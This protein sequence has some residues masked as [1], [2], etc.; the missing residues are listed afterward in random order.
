MTARILSGAYRDARMKTPTLVLVGADD[1]IGPE[2]LHGID[3]HVDDFAMEYVEGAKE[4]CVSPLPAL[5]VMRV[6]RETTRP[7]WRRAR[8][9]RRR[10]PIHLTLAGHRRVDGKAPYDCPHA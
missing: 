7:Y 8:Q 6:S 5:T 2:F 10:E 4:S 1:R 9:G 3:E